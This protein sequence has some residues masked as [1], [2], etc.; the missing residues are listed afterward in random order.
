MDFVFTPNDDPTFIY[1]MKSGA[2]RYGKIKS[3]CKEIDRSD[4]DINEKNKAK[5]EI[6]YKYYPDKKQVQEAH[7]QKSVEDGLM[8][9]VAD[10]NLMF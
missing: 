8:S 10:D 6:L 9:I 5:W 7:E 3:E 1:N 2:E 4:N